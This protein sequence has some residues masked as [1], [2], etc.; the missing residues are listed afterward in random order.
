VYG[1]YYDIA[2][3]PVEALSLRA[4]VQSALSHAVIRCLHDWQM[5]LTSVL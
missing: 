3:F 4:V 2:Q 5:P 1:K